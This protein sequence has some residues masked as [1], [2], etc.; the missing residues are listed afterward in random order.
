MWAMGVLE[1]H[2]P[3]NHTPKVLTDVG[4]FW[5]SQLQGRNVLSYRTR[6]QPGNL[7]NLAG[8]EYVVP[9][10]PTRWLLFGPSGRPVCGIDQLLDLDDSDP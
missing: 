4:A 6:A 8:A 10:D 1:C 5:L 7:R 9:K 3:D 2:L